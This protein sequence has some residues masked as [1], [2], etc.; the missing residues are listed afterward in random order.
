MADNFNN[1]EAEVAAFYAEVEQREQEQ[2]GR[3]A[4]EW[5]DAYELSLIDEDAMTHAAA[6]LWTDMQLTGRGA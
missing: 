5:A 6:E 3:E 1:H 2:L 4:N